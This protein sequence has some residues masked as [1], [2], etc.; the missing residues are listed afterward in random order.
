MVNYSSRRRSANR[1]DLA[2]SYFRGGTNERQAGRL[3][4][5]ICGVL[6]KSNDN[7]IDFRQSV[8]FQNLSIVLPEDAKCCCCAVHCFNFSFMVY[9]TCRLLFLQSQSL[10]IVTKF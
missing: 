1:F 10:L 4:E 5:P 7:W 6:T 8:N 3:I 9:N 2:M